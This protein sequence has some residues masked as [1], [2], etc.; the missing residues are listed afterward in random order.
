MSDLFGNHFVGFPTW[1]LIFKVQKWMAKAEEIKT[2]LEVKKL[3]A[4]ENN[5]V[6][7]D[8]QEEAAEKSILNSGKKN[9]RSH[10]TIV[11]G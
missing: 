10:M 4:N 11:V 8:Q 9:R 2:Y 6:E 7:K 1:R 3:N 5:S